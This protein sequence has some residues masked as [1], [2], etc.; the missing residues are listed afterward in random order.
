MDGC[1]VSINLSI[2]IDVSPPPPPPHIYTHTYNSIRFSELSWFW[3]PRKRWL[4]PVKCPQCST[5][6]P[7]DDIK[8]NLSEDNDL[9]QVEI[10]CPECNQVFLHMPKYATG[11]PR[12]IALIGH[13]DGW[14]PFGSTGTHSCGK[15]V[16]SALHAST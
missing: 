15:H 9:E 1:P 11:D 12:N 3:D 16:P 8:K 2:N 13:W 7:T 4:L 10:V 14:Q 5:V 6:V